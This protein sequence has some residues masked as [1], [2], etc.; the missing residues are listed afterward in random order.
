MIEVDAVSKSFGARPAVQDLT[1][2][3]PAGTVTCLL[4][5]NGAGKT[6]LLRLIAGLERPDSG[7]VRVVGA[8]LADRPDPLRTLG[9]QLEAM[10]PGHTVARHLRW[11]AALGGIR[12]RRVD[13][14]LD[15]VGLAD[16][17]DQRIGSLS[18]GARQR[19][20]IGATLLGNPRVYLF[21]EPLNGLDVPGIVWMRDLLRGLADTGRTVV[22]ASHLLSEVVLTADRV[23]ILAAGRVVTDGAIGDVVPPG[24]EPREYLEDRLIGAGR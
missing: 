7:T 18:T 9:V 14:V 8:R 13:E 5:L 6:T 21:D 4:G 10:D 20:S 2:T 16:R 12:A 1:A 24:R 11:L 22:M 3:F 23:T 15:S 19:L 17:R